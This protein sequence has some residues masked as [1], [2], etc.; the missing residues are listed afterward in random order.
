M[1]AY[2]RKHIIDSE[3]KRE[4]N[5]VYDESHNCV[6]FWMRRQIIVRFPANNNP[7][8]CMRWRIHSFS[9]LSKSPVFVKSNFLLIDC[10]VDCSTTPYEEEE[11]KEAI[12]VVSANTNGIS[13]LLNILISPSSQNDNTFKQSCQ[14][15]TKLR[16]S[17][18]RN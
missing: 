3:G 7:L 10:F 11:T 17:F 15:D 12:I 5:D 13:S 6:S 14:L 16:I 8:K 4:E 9:D 18:K 1:N 2:S